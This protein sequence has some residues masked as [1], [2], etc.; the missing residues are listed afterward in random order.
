[1]YV[2]SWNVQIVLEALNDDVITW[3]ISD[4]GLE[5]LRADIRAGE[6]GRAY[7]KRVE[8]LETAG[9]VAIAA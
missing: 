8:P 6:L 3:T 2:N 7:I 9:L 1:L 4:E 5:R